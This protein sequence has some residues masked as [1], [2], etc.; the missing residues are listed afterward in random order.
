M[1]SALS[2][3]P[4]GANFAMRFIAPGTAAAGT[5]AAAAGLGPGLAV[6][7]TEDTVKYLNNWQ[8]LHIAI[9]GYDDFTIPQRLLAW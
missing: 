5:V 4:L 7:V 1:C 3:V 9:K 6:P 8:S 2:D